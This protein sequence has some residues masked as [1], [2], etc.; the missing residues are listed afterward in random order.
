MSKRDEFK[1]KVKSIL[2]ER[3]GYHCCNPKCRALTTGPEVNAGGSIRLGQAAHIT[4]AAPGGPRYDPN[5]TPEQRSS[6]ENGV[7]LCIKC[8]TL[9]DKGEKDY[10]VAT[11]Q[12]WKRSGEH[13]AREG[14]QHPHQFASGSLN[15]YTI[16]TVYR[17][18]RPLSYFPLRG[19]PLPPGQE[20]RQEVT[21]RPM[22]GDRERA[23]NTTFAPIC[24]DSSFGPSPNATAFVL[25]LENVGKGTEPKASINLKMKGAPIWKQ[26]FSTEERMSSTYT[27]K[28][29]HTTGI[30][31]FSVLNLMPGES[32]HSVLYSNRKGPFDA[33]WFCESVSKTSTPMIFDVLAGKVEKV[34]VLPPNPEFDK[35]QFPFE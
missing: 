1:S 28:K 32:F 8:A 2:A 16:A 3:A 18:T 19:K 17:H 23:E 29:S 15:A 21:L 35:E 30:A 6:Q 25:H 31:G 13:A 33:E 22:G 4:A 5:L 12:E 9:I 10:S 26:T 24:L 7:W 14:L 27:L 34:P 20:F 11:I